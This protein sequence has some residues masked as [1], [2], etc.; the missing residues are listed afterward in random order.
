VRENLAHLME[1]KSTVGI[2]DRLATVEEYFASVDLHRFLS[3]EKDLLR[4]FR[5][6]KEAR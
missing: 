4:P 5:G 2:R 1:H 6:G 3:L